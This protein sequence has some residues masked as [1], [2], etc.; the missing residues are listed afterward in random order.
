MKEAVVVNN[1]RP[2]I[3]DS[4][5]EDPVGIREIFIVSFVS[6]QQEDSTDREKERENIPWGDIVHLQ[7]RLTR[8]QTWCTHA[9]FIP[10]NVFT[11]N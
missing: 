10:S 4:W 5:R 2:K 1:L 6:I 8:A 3:E 7:C 11:A 9:H